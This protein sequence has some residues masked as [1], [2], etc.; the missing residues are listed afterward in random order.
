LTYCTLCSNSNSNL[1]LFDFYNNT[2]CPWVQTQDICHKGMN[3]STE[4][5]VPF[6]TSS[7]G[8]NPSAMYYYF[9]E[10]TFY[11]QK[12]FTT[13]F[14]TPFIDLVFP[15]ILVFIFVV[16]LLFGFFFILIP[17]IIVLI[18]TRE[19]KF[20]IL[21]FFTLRVISQFH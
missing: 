15:F 14:L 11:S 4:I 20:N 2:N 13:I 6:V 21:L 10:Q 12:D 3:S 19:K 5:C 18:I 1:T 17:E 7:S 9:N 16:Y 8:K